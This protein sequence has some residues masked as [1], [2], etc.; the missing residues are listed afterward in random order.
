MDKSLGIVRSI[1]LKYADSTL[2]EGLFGVTSLAS[3]IAQSHGARE[4]HT[5]PTGQPFSAHRPDK[6]VD[7]TQPG[8]S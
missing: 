3:S 6:T 1:I 8:L 7:C 2:V 5:S 4:E